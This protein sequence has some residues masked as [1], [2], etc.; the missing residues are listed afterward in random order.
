MTQTAEFCKVQVLDAGLF[1]R[2]RQGVA[3]ELRVLARPGNGADIHQPFY[4]VSLEQRQEVIERTI[5]VIDCQ[6]H[7][8]NIVR[9]QPLRL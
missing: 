2:E 1:Q 4:S 5:R 7:I 6:Y 8:P 9:E 3:V